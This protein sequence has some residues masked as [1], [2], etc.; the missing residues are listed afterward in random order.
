MNSC[1]LMAQIVSDPELRQT[2]DGTNVANMLVEF[3]SARPEDPTSKLRVV[4][5]GGLAEEISQRYKNGDR[6]IIDGRLAMNLVDMPEG[7]KEKRAEL[8]ISRI[9]PLDSSNQSYPSTTAT[10]ISQKT[11]SNAVNLEPVRVAQP[12]PVSTEVSPPPQM[13]TTPQPAATPG[14][15]TDEQLDDIPF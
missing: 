9:F 10:S 3:E 4:G 1:V 2:Q 15:Y 12:K 14:N 11:P 6:V 7:Y 8:V 13:E 5:W